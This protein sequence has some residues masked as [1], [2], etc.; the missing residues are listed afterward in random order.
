MIVRDCEETLRPLL[1]SL[2]PYV[3]EII[4]GLGGK[5]KDRTEQI[6]RKYADVI[7]PIEWKDD[8]AYARNEVLKQVT[9]EYW[10]WFDGDDVVDKPEEIPGILDKMD[11]HKIDRVDMV[12]DYSFDKHGNLMLSHQ[13]ER[14]LR[15]SK[16]WRWL[17]RVHETPHSDEA[18]LSALTDDMKVIHQRREEGNSAA[19]NLPILLEMARDEPKARTFAGLANAYYSTGKYDEAVQWFTEYLK[20]PE[21]V[22]GQWSAHCM[23]ARCALLLNDFPKAQAWAMMAAGLLP[24]YKDPYVLLAQATWYGDRDVERT[25]AWIRMAKGAESAPLAQFQLPMDNLTQLADI[26]HRVFATKQMWPEALEVC[27]NISELLPENLE[28]THYLVFYQECVRASQSRAAALHLAD[29]MVRHGDVVRAKGLLDNFLPS[30]IRTDPAI[31]GGRARLRAILETPTPEEYEH[32][33]TVSD[34]DYPVEIW[35]RFQFYL[36]RLRASGAKKVLEVGCH[37]GQ[38][39]RSLAKLGFETVGVDFNPRIVDLANAR[40]QADGLNA[41]FICGRLEDITEKFD[42]VLL[43]EVLEHVAPSVQIQM[44][45]LAE[46]LAPQVL[47]SVPAE[48]VGLC[49]GLFEKSRIGHEL[50]RPHIFE[51]DQN[52]MEALILTDPAREIVNCHKVPWSLRTDMIPGFGNL[53]FEFRQRRPS[54]GIGICFYLGEG[55]EYWT[56]NDIDAKGIGGSE[57]AAVRL[58]EELASR[59]HHVSVYGPEQGVYNGVVYRHYSMFDPDEPREVVIVSRMLAH[60][61]KRPAAACVILWSH[62]IGYGSALTQELADNV[63]KMVVMSDWQKE[64]WHEEYPFLA[65]EKVVPIGNAIKLY[66]VDEQ[67]VPHRF[68]YSSSPDRGLDDILYRWGAIREMWPDAELHIF[69]GWQYLDPVSQLRPYKAQLQQMMKQEGV[70]WHGRTGQATLAEEF[71]KAQFW[72]YPSMLP[73]EGDEV[74]PDFHE[75][76]CITALEAQAYGCIPVTRPVGAIAERLERG[77]FDNHYVEPWTTEGLLATLKAFDEGAQSVIQAGMRMNAT[78]DKYTWKGVADKWL[79]LIA[80][81]LLEGAEVE[82]EVP[83]GE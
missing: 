36:E 80:A 53:A 49:E 61:V 62:D 64:H 58:A 20:A 69:Y 75:T 33:D 37:N 9:G 19:R 35:P 78:Q 16:N 46:Q 29:H 56:P 79:M 30:T 60:I 22:F 50:F 57:T 70:F 11:E 66:D 1:V 71:A 67:R 74:G 13:R 76:F 42:A 59:G 40:A 73:R 82:E 38:I 68:I 4:V 39:S 54:N 21:D 15:T 45:N 27:K 17:D 47:G 65:P 6:A 8:W 43:A 51:F 48:P 2:R 83:I 81:H 31:L 25:E 24:Q 7:V 12:Y 10:C 3:D 14:I 72:L 32:A 55:W 26:E 18:I 41:R 23:G 77:H 5:S 34:D 28:W 44:L 63:D 52:D